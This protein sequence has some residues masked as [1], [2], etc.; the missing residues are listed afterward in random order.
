VVAGGDWN[1][2]PPNLPLN[3][4]GA[5]YQVDFFK[6][7]NID[8]DFMPGNWKWV[9][10][11]ETPTNRYLNEAYTPGQTCRCLIDIFLVSPNVQV[12]QNRTFDLNFR[13]S[14]HNPIEMQFK[15]VR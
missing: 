13:N 1:Q 10:D 14:D 6:L 15:L 3:K 4:F 11:P 5:N 8:A 12:L 9:F 7:T 2:S